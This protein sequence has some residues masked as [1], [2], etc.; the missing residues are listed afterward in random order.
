MRNHSLRTEVPTTSISR[1]CV[2]TFMYSGAE[3]TLLTRG[4]R[5]SRPRGSSSSTS[6]SSSSRSSSSSSSLS[7][8]FK[9]EERAID[10]RKSFCLN[11]RLA[12]PNSFSPNSTAWA[13]MSVSRRICALRAS[14]MLSSFRLKRTG[15]RQ[16][17]R[18]EDV[19]RLAWQVEMRRSRPQRRC[20]T[21]RLPSGSSFTVLFTS[22]RLA[23][24]LGGAAT[25][26]PSCA[27][28]GFSSIASKKHSVSSFVRRGSARF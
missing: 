26:S 2:S 16:V 24:S 23:V 27:G 6:S 15:T 11:W 7:F 21:T 3:T 28:A 4:I 18:S 13:S 12:S 10:L 14:S 19:T 20:S 8:A 25:S 9:T 17:A 5:C 22:A 1:F